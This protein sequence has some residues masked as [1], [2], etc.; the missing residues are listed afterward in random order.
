MNTSFLFITYYIFLK[1]WDGMTFGDRLKKLR[2]GK[3]LTLA[4]LEDR[5]D[6][7]RTAFSNYEN[8]HRKPN[9]NLVRDLADFFEVSVDFLLGREEEVKEEPEKIELVPIFDFKNG[10]ALLVQDNIIGYK[11]VPEKDLEGGEYFYLRINGDDSMVNAGIEDNDLVFIK[12]Q[13]E[14]KDG[15]IALIKFKDRFI[16]RYLYSTEDQYIIETANP[17][18]KLKF[19]NHGEVEIIGKAVEIIRR[20]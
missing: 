12:N 14:I 20:L 1:G 2:K 9:M 10:Q 6:R 11:K 19:L 7:G 18:Y 13:D 8:N 3:G 17:N 4:D 5:F 16:L 15:D